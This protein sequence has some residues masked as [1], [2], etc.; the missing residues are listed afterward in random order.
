[1]PRYEVT[2]GLAETLRSIRLQNKI[3]ANKLAVH[4]GKSPA[5]ISKLENGSIQTI[6]PDEL[7]KILRFISG[8]A[9]STELAEQIYASLKL[10]YS[11]KEI[12]EQLWFTNYDTVECRIPLP[13]ALIEDLIK[14]I[15]V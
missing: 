5:Y 3:Q 6:T 14:K 12:E 10:K 4:I 15:E 13:P 8:E 2:P 11:A 7:S 1:M 9:H